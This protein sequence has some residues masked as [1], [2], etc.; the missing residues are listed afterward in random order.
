MAWEA[1]LVDALSRCVVGPMR[2]ALFPCQRA[3]QTM[4]VQR[5]ER[6]GRHGACTGSW[7]DWHARRA[8]RQSW[9][10]R[11]GSP[12]MALT[13]G[14]RSGDFHMSPEADCRLCWVPDEGSHLH[15]LVDCAVVSP[16]GLLG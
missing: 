16:T 11:S 12:G 8:E 6:S 15:Q 14:A 13:R 7:L 9:S 2:L 10:A 4:F 1:V 5:E 3:L